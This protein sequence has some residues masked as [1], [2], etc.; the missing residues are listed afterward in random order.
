MFPPQRWDQNWVFFVDG[1]S[2]K[3]KATGAAGAAVIF[4]SDTAQV[5]EKRLFILP[6]DI[7][8]LKA[9]LHAIAEGLAIA[10]TD[11]IRAGNQDVP[12][13][14]GNLPKPKVTIFSDCQYAL[15]SLARLSRVAST[16]KQVRRNPC[17]RKLIT[18][19]QY[20]YGLGTDVRLRWVPGHS[21]VKGNT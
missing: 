9:E 21:D 16:E 2:S 3:G 20:L 8:F 14:K 15:G 13:S 12:G 17:L 11:V 10:V 18:R 4:F 7:G 6:G 19:S 1:A 5:W